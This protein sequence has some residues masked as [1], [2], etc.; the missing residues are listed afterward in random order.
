[1][2]PKPI[3]KAALICFILLTASGAVGACAGR[4]KAGDLAP[5]A[6]ANAGKL[7]TRQ[8]AIRGI[9]SIDRTDIWQDSGVGD[10]DKIRSF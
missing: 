4:A 5:A 3:L 8:H 2:N 1:M 10:P 9:V 7:D 6:R